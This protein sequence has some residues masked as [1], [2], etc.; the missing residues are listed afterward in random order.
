[1][2]RTTALAVTTAL[3]TSLVLPGAAAMAQNLVLEEIVVTARKIEENLMEVPLAI[4]AFSAADI[5]KR[6]LS[7]LNDIQL[8]T[9]SFAFTDMSG[10]SGRNDRGSNVLT[11]RGLFLGNNGG[12][13]AGGQMFIDGAP[14]IGAHAPSTSDIARIEVLKGPQAAYFGRS[15]FIGAINFVS[16]EPGDEFSGRVT[17]EYGRWGSNEQTLSLEGPII[18]GKFNLR[19]GARHTAQGGYYD[20]FANPSVEFGARDTK[21]VS[22]TALFTPTENLKAKLYVNFFENNDGPP[23]QVALKQESFTGRANRDGTCTPFSTPLGAGEDPT[24]RANLGA[25]CGTL[26]SV[27]EIDPSFISGDYIIND[28]LQDVLFDSVNPLLQ[29]FDPNFK[30]DGGTK[31]RGLQAT[32]R[33]DYETG[34]GYSIS[35][36]SAL[37]K[38][39][40]QTVLDL[41]YRD[42]HDRPNPFFNNPFWPFP[43]RTAHQNNTLLTQGKQRDWSQEIRISSPQDERFRWTAGANYFYAYSPG[44]TVY[45]NIAFAGQFFTAAIQ[46]T[47]VKTPAV[48]G[49]AYYDITDD[50][51]LSVEARY[52]W[53]KISQTLIVPTNGI[54]L[55][56]PTPLEAT[57]KS[58]SP[59]VSLD[60][61]YSENST[62]YA[63]YSSGVRPGGFNSTLTASTPATLAALAAVVPN[64]GVTFEEEKIKNYEI[65][66]KS[67]WLDGRARTTVAVYQMDW[68]NGQNVNAIPVVADGVANLIQLTINNGLAKLQGVEFEGQFQA[69][70]NLTFSATF[71]LNDTEVKDLIC[72]QC[73]ELYGSFDANGNELHT[74]PKYTWTIG[75]EYTDSLSNNMDWYTRFDLAHQGGRFTDAGNVTKT[76]SYDNLTLRAGLRTE[77]F[78]LEAFVL[79]ALNHDEFLQGGHGIDLASFGP[80]GPSLNEVRLALPIPRSYGIRASY[81]F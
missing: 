24:T 64:A 58:F 48:F 56:N 25:I 65:G 71:G 36:L 46:Q 67:T 32:L 5:E 61:N 55:A 38:D 16:R 75:G 68:L 17:A 76:G 18:P 59:R 21:S 81:N 27:S 1:M 52:Q 57:Y 20:N 44:G 77:E 50:L 10:N 41:N 9:P 31:R 12:V 14:I 72:G 13:S 22:A 11:F 45:G 34:S 40:Q 23:A 54:P 6:D 73:N 42:F 26:P 39:R 8:Y 35:S 70:E 2:K 43:T 49:A 78:T 63:L 4:T 74:V 7:D 33:L 29:I 53:D 62:V 60:Y 37:H 69:T 19:V 80:F 3:V 79:N 47:K 66:V 51:T 28:T 30:R 15:T